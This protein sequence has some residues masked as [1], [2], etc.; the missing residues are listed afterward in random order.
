MVAD[1]A[2]EGV[3]TVFGIVI[4]AS[5]ILRIGRIIDALGVGL[6]IVDGV[7]AITVVDGIGLDKGGVLEEPLAHP[8]GT[9]IGGATAGAAFHRTCIDGV[10]ATAIS[11]VDVTGQGVGHACHPEGLRED[12]EHG[13][14]LNLISDQHAA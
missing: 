10:V 13:V 14:F 8:E 6:Q 9:C 2:V 1:E 11:L 12:A 7:D 3:T 4:V 5:G